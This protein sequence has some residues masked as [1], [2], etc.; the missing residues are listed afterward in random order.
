M[1]KS[2]AIV[3]FS[4]SF[5]LCSCKGKSNHDASLGIFKSDKNANTN[6]EEK[7]DSTKLTTVAFTDS[8]Q[9]FGTVKKGTQVKLVYHF[10]NTGKFPLYIT[11]VEP[12]CGCTVADYSKEAILPGKSGTINAVFDSNHGTAGSVRKSI[13]VSSNTTNAPNYVLAFI[14]EIAESK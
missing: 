7:I 6:A 1:V 11:N 4:A 12:S 2:L 9:N 10:T 3:I 8:T 14:G 5:A 13:I